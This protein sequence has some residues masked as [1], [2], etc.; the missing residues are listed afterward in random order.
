[1]PHTDTLLI[2]I[3]SKDADLVH[4]RELSNHKHDNSESLE[5]EDRLLVV[6]SVRGAQVPVT[7]T[8]A[9]IVMD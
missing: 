4:V 6:C 2:G 5:D 7:L 1:M 9:I 3:D 8:K